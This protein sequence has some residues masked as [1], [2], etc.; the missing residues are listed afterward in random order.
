VLTT[1]GLHDQLFLSVFQVGAG[2]LR[3]VSPSWG[4][5][6]RIGS[7]VGLYTQHREAAEI[8]RGEFSLRGW[9]RT[10]WH[11]GRSAWEALVRVSALLNIFTEGIVRI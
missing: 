11:L 4:E 3:G 7:M 9:W 8:F 2:Q 5:I 6:V 1:T 10:L